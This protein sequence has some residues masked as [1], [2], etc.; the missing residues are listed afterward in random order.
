MKYLIKDKRGFTV[1]LLEVSTADLSVFQV[2]K[3]LTNFLRERKINDA[4]KFYVIDFQKY[5]AAKYTIR[6]VEHMFDVLNLQV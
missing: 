5:L 4:V 3:E 1:G 2:Q 6:T